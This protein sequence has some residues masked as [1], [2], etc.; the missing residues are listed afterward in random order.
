MGTSNRHNGPG[1]IHGISRSESA[2][3]RGK[4]QMMMLPSFCELHA[5]VLTSLQDS[6]PN[7]AIKGHYGHSGHSGH[8]G[9][10]RHFGLWLWT[11]YINPLPEEFMQSFTAIASK[12]CL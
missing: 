7:I 6:W 5:Y 8:F 9:Q 1:S 3:T 4:S 10:F 11:L 2:I 12:M